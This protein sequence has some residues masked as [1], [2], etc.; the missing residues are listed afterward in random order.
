M[1]GDLAPYA[2]FI[3]IIIGVSIAV[4]LAVTYHWISDILPVQGSQIS[5][6]AKLTNYCVEFRKNGWKKPYEYSE[7]NPKD[8]QKFT[9]ANDATG[10]DQIKC[11]QL[12][13]L[14]QPK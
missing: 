12:L 7:K 11:E 1:K 4:M 8:C 13:G 3:V 10:P 9:G 2:I 14:S 6:G 5:C